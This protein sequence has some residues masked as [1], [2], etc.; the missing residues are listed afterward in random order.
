MDP[1]DVTFFRARTPLVVIGVFSGFLILLTAGAALNPG[2]PSAGRIACGAMAVGLALWSRLWWR[3]GIVAGADGVVVRRYS[4]RAVSVPWTQVHGF[5][6]V[7]N[8]KGGSWIAVQTV[9]GDVLKT[10]G[11]AASSPTS[12]WGRRVVAE[13]EHARPRST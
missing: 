5:A 1:T 7:P 4:G 12:D 9:G 10:Q 13:L 2:V 8:G 3:A 11:L 6:L